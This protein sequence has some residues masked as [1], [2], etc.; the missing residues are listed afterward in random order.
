MAR[1]A[2]TNDDLLAMALV[3]YEVQIGKIN[4]AIREIQ[5]KLG[6]HGPGRPR[7]ATDGAAPA[8][9]FMSA[10]G[11]R[12][13]A[14]AQRKRWAA[15]KKA[16]AKSAAKPAVPKKRKLSAAGRRLIRCPTGQIAG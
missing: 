15:L 16:Q 10:A 8:K 11:R 6:H 5:A 1:H 4:A 13:I 3:G 12:H 7:A 2:G 9:R 14:A